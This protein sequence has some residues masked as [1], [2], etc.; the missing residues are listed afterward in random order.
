MKKW[1]SLLLALGIPLTTLPPEALAAIG[2]EESFFMDMPAVYVASK[3]AESLLEASGTVYVITED[4][5]RRYGWRDLQQILTALPNVDLKWDY[6][7]MSGGQRGFTGGFNGTVLMVDGREVSNLIANEAMMSWTMPADRI[8]RVEILQGPGSSLYGTHALQ[9]VINIITKLALDEKQ[10]VNQ[11]TYTGGTTNLSQVGGTFRKDTQDATIGVSLSQVRDD[12]DW[13]ELKDFYK[14]N[15]DYSRNTL[16]L[17]RNP[18][19][20]ANKHRSQ[21]L[22][23]VF[24]YKDVYAGFYTHGFMNYAGIETVKIDQNAIQ[25]DRQ[26]KMSYVGLKHAFGDLS[27]SLEVRHDNEAHLFERPQN[28][29]TAAWTNYGNIQVANR[30][31]NFLFD[32]KTVTGQ[33]Q[34]PLGQRNHLTSGFTW[35]LMRQ[36]MH[37]VDDRAWGPVDG[38]VRATFRNLF[39]QG[40]D[41]VEA[42]S[43]FVQ[44]AITILPEKL[45]LTIGTSFNKHEL[46]KDTFATRGSLVFTPWKSAAFKLNY[47]EGFRPGSIFELES[48][49]TLAKTEPTEMKMYEANYSQ[50]I[51]TGLFDIQNIFAA[52]QMKYTNQLRV[53]QGT[54][55]SGSL[56]VTVT[57]PDFKVN[58]FEDMLRF[59]RNRLSG[60]LGYRYVAPQRSRVAGVDERINVPRSKYKLGVSADVFSKMTA[61]VFID[62]WDKVR[63]SANAIGAS[64]LPI[65]TAGGAIP[66]ELR[67]APAWT[68]AHLNVVFGEFDMGGTKTSLSVYVENLTNKNYN[69]ANVR[70]TSP[71]QVLQ[72][73]RTVNITGK[74]SF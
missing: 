28:Q 9:G 62:R 22:N 36:E 53:I 11:V 64:A 73:P 13:H 4:D 18:E 24:R 43:L 40:L 74:V 50:E 6:N 67:T 32:K 56:F 51:H 70:G 14:S 61:S 68:V 60:F 46:I 52:Y 7:W 31:Q 39:S 15:T 37:E 58:G 35:S 10:D 42:S 54:G 57:D 65:T 48:V 5:I 44:D 63:Y 21:S 23:A 69:H 19:G 20:F 41:H 38:S 47:G 71:I 25:H 17:Y 49:T 72:P 45:K 16:D 12:Q 34:M 26:R 8:K 30:A 55:P 66:T 2:A 1:L 33:A 59:S 3:K 27:T 29:N